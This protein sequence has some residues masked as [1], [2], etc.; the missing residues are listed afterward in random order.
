MSLFKSLIAAVALSVS[1]LCGA[2]AGD[3]ALILS[4]R[5]YEGAGSEP[6]AIAVAPLRDA[7]RN[8]GYQVFGGESWDVQQMGQ[9]AARFDAALRRGS[10]DRVV[11]VVSGR[12]AES[13]TDQ[14][15]LGRYA[16]DVSYLNAG[17]Q[18]L[19]L[20]ALDK[21]LA[22]YPGRTLMVVAPAMRSR[23]A[24]G[25]GLT[26]GA[27]GLEPSQ[28]VALMVGPSRLVLP[29]LRTQVLQ[30]EF[31]MGQV[32]QS[33]PNGLIYRGY[34][35]LDL[36]LGGD[37]APVDQG[38]SAYWSAARDINLL[39]GYRAYLNRFPNGLFADEARRQIDALA[40]APRRQAEAAEQAL[41][42]T[43]ND[44]R[45]I[46]KRLTRLGF[47]TAGI[48]G[49]FGRGSRAA[50]TRYQRSRGFEDS[51]YLN[52]EVVA[53]IASDAAQREAEERARREELEREDRRYWQRTGASGL[54]TDL[55]AYLDRY[56]DGLFADVAKERL[57]GFG[58]TDQEIRRAWARADRE[59]TLEAYQRFSSRYP[60]SPFTAEAEARI[61]RLQAETAQVAQ[62]AGRDQAEERAVAANPVSR[63]LVERGLA[64]S[65]FDP[66]PVDGVF[67]DQ[68]RAALRN[69]Q[70]DEGMIP[71]GFVSQ[72]TMLRLT[73]R[74]VR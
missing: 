39:E 42:L 40:D 33:A 19:S 49:I 6:E 60:G 46:Q 72:A 7:F 23:Q 17:Q 24:V 11:V 26:T 50:I 55:Q 74:A 65:G 34:L 62:Q 45:R 12:V 29:S 32:A 47:D 28:G 73:V 44:K 10:V 68:S 61:A 71:T 66:G 67:D 54:E 4:N 43:R 21:M 5:I 41:N 48:D 22:A 8:A 20:T 69:F 14:W 38:D 63:L 27:D 13:T 2:I 9:E 30:A 52:A 64:K 36:P 18:G 57:R 1:P 58:V 51:G 56:P 16:R 15:L 37:Q 3:Y 59:N 25:Y 31:P 70:R 53:R 35:P